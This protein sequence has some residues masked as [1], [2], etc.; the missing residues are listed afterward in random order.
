MGYLDDFKKFVGSGGLITLAVAFIMAT[1]LNAVVSALVVDFIT[2]LIGV[3]FKFNLAAATTQVN[4]SVF[5]YGD[6]LNKVLTFLI[7]AL[8]VFFLIVEPLEKYQA[9][10]AAKLAAAPPTTRACPE[11]QSQVPIAAKRCA[12]CTQPLPAA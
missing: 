3:F 9:R 2:P 11:C 5:A 12:F 6:F 10:K 7:D 8:V 4:G 1:A